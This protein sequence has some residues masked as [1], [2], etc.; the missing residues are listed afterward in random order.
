M[1]TKRDD[2]RKNEV[3]VELKYCERCGALWMR[4]C[5]SGMIYCNGC[6]TDVTELP[7]LKKRPQ[8]VKLGMGQGRL[9]R[10]STSTRA[11]NRALNAH[12]EVR[13][14]RDGGM[15]CRAGV[16][17]DSELR[18]DE[19]KAGEEGFAKQGAGVPAPASQEKGSPEKN[20]RAHQLPSDGDEPIEI[21]GVEDSQI[22]DEGGVNL[23]ELDYATLHA[24]EVE[25]HEREWE[26]RRR[27]RELQ[28]QLT[29]IARR[30]CAGIADGRWH[31]CGVTCVWRWRQGGCLRC[32][33]RC[34]FGL[35]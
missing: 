8:T 20:L 12:G 11:R 26:E 28:R 14:E 21:Q 15:D 5:G 27:A 16:R 3:R 6:Q 31:C 32:W 13:R 30:T 7:M 22:V 25:K 34:F 19:A 9:L 35:G 17:R 24:L 2:A 1:K 29:S 33:D 10:T 18:I 4:E 23:E